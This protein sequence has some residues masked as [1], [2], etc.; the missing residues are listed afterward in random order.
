MKLDM[1][2]D[3]IMQIKPYKNKYDNLVVDCPHCSDFFYVRKAPNPLRGL[4]RHIVVQAKNEALEYYFDMHSKT[5]HLTYFKQH[6]TNKIT[7][8]KRVFDDDMELSPALSTSKRIDKS[9]KA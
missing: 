7:V 1:M 6:S 9:S 4:Q 2:M 3:H 8:N 5:P